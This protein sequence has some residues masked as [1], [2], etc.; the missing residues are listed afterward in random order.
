MT[1]EDIY[2]QVMGAVSD[3]LPHIDAEEYEDLG[4]E[5]FMRLQR[6]RNNDNDP[7]PPPRKVPRR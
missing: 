6:L 1:V 5:V 4:D 7:L 3:V 2:T